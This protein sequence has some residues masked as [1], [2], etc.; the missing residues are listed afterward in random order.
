M[1]CDLQAGTV[2]YVVDDRKRESLE[3]YY[4]QFS[5]EELS[6][7][8]A[9]ALDMWEPFIAATTA[10]VPQAAAKMVF[11]RFHL[12]RYVTEAV[13]KVRRQ[14]SA[15]LAKA[16]CEKKE[17]KNQRKKE[18]KISPVLSCPVLEP[19]GSAPGLALVLSP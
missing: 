2:E 10:R 15:V 9:I 14:E 6:G 17:R 7:I 13:D 8:K 16:G 5:T 4:A 1:V 12:T 18:R 19:P 11:D 3:S